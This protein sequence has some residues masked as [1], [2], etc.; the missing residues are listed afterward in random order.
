M[1]RVSAATAL[2]REHIQDLLDG[3]GLVGDAV[4]LDDPTPEDLELIAGAL[5]EERE[6]GE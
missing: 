2:R 6:E 3:M 4:R 1:K 5:D